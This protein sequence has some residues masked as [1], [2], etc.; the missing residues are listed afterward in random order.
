MSIYG[1]QVKPQYARM[2]VWNLITLC[3]Y[4]DYKSNY[5]MSIYGQEV[6]PQYVQYVGMKSNWNMSIYG[7]KVKPQYARIWAKN[8]IAICLLFMVK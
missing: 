3:S 1:Q 2:L 5:N 6:K 8:S 7:Q 4:I